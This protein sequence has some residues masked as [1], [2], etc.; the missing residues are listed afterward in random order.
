MCKDCRKKR[1]RNTKKIRADKVE[2]RKLYAKCGDIDYLD[3]KKIRLNGQN[4]STTFANTGTVV[5]KEFE[6]IPNPIGDSQTY[7]VFGF[8]VPA[9]IY[10]GNQQHVLSQVVSNLRIDNSSTNITGGEF[11]VFVLYQLPD[12]QN[13]NN[14]ISY[15]YNLVSR[16]FE[17]LTP[18]NETSAEFYKNIVVN[19][20]EGTLNVSPT[21][22][23]TNAEQE[24]F[25]AQQL[26]LQPDLN[27][28]G[29]VF[30]YLLANISLSGDLLDIEKKDYTAT[31][32][33]PK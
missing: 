29:T 1:R 2:T 21:T 32:S 8:G 19:P 31:Y 33:V 3:S 18:N 15:A 26:A 16:Q 5:R 25:L 23:F 11:V 12:P 24:A 10:F 7:E 20:P 13:P 27:G 30:Y 6:V 22:Q 4:I 14:I 17:E 28:F 9:V